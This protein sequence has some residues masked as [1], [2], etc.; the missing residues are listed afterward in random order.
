M[1]SDGT[2]TPVMSTNGNAR[3]TIPP[4]SWIATLCPNPAAALT[5]SP[6][7]GW[8]CTRGWKPGPGA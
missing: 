4:G 5:R 1:P 3:R 6:K 7:G 8:S 2:A